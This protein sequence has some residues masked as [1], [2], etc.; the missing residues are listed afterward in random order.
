[1]VGSETFA[2]FQI[3]HHEVSKPVDVTRRPETISFN[4]KTDDRNFH[5]QLESTCLQPQL[6]TSEHANESSYL[7]LNVMYEYM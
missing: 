6:K 4:V 2:I 1:M 5:N 3:L 7:P